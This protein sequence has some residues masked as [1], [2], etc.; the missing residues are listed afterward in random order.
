MKVV[1]FFTFSVQ[2]KTYVRLFNTFAPWM[3]RSVKGAE[4]DFRISIDQN[5]D[6]VIKLV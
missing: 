4:K 3:P 2:E 1:F 6:D 5:G